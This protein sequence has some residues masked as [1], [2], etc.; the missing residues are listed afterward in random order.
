MLKRICVAC[1]AAAVVCCPVYCGA[2]EARRAGDQPKTETG[3][4]SRAKELLTDAAIIAI[5]IAAS[6]A[7]YHAGAKG[8]CGCPDDVDRAGHRCGGRSAHD[9]AG[10][11]S[12]LCFPNEITQEMIAKFRAGQIK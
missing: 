10:G 5:L 7:A 3:S 1:V 2:D 4:I 12:V 11:W 9:R 6:Q 8:P